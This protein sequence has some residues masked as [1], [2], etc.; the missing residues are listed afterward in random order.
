MVY[1]LAQKLNWRL[2]TKLL[3]RWHVQVINKDDTL[4][5]HW[6]PKHSLSSFV[7]PG[8]DDIL[9]DSTETHLVNIEHSENSDFIF[10]ND[11]C[12]KH[13]PGTIGTFI[14]C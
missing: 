3:Q 5:S 9:V 7:Q 6:R 12:F 10:V 14:F 4:F 8:H 13:N 1:E 2:C 11:N